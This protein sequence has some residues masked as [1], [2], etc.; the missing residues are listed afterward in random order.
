MNKLRLG[1]AILTFVLI[2][3]GCNKNKEV[4][5]ND[6]GIDI[7]FRRLQDSI[8][9]YSKIKNSTV[10]QISVESDDAVQS[11]G[12]RSY[13]YTI[14]NTGDTAWSGVLRF[15]LQINGKNPRFFL[16]GFIYG[17][18][19]AEVPIH[20]KNRKQWPR[21]RSG[22]TQ[23]PYS[24]YFFVRSDRLA[25]PVSMVYIN[26]RVYGISASP[27]RIY[28]NDTVK[29]WQPKRKGDF[30]GFNG[31]GC[32]LDTA[33]AT[34]SYTLGYE[35]APWLYVAGDITKEQPF[36]DSNCFTI[37]PEE[38]RS[39]VLY[40]YDFESEDERGIN[41]V[42]RHQN[43][44]FHEPPTFKVS[45]QTALKDLATAVY[46]D[47]YSDEIKLYVTSLRLINDTV[48]KD[49]SASIAW[50]GGLQVATPLLMA[51]VRLKNNDMRNQAVE[52]VQNVVDNS[53]NPKSGL[54]F[55]AYRNG[56][57]TTEGWWEY[58]L[59]KPLEGIAAHSSYLCGQALYYILKA[60]EYEKEYYNN[61]HKDWL[62]FVKQVSNRVE[63]TKNNDG[64]YP[65]RWS[66]ETGE[67]ID[68]DAMGG[69]WCLATRAYLAKILNDANMI[70]E[71]EKSIDHYWKKFVKKMECYGT[72]HDTWRATEE[73]GILAFVKAAGILHRLTENDKYLTYLKDGIDYEFTWKYCYNTPVQ[74]PP[75]SKLNWSSSGASGT[76]I[77][78]PHVHPMGCSISDDILYLAEKTGDDYYQ[79][80]AMDV[81]YWPVQAYNS[82]HE[83]FDHGKKGWMSERF[84]PHEG[85]VIEK[86]P[87][88]S[89]ASTWFI[90]HPWASG[91]AIEALAGN[92]WNIITAEK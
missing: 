74:I 43:A 47:A 10:L 79:Q 60:Y 61:E 6:V 76:S 31:F 54:P 82:Y 13:Q 81:V 90:Y 27:Y 12:I 56:E 33:S 83:K 2:F 22:D 40:L 50:T 63:T 52:C 57:W 62:Q 26:G 78:N 36:S 73:E 87:D 8:K 19:R 17:T 23:M 34:I 4:D 24:D 9:A 91:S 3:S 59:W 58:Y 39:F 55:D 53:L 30:S 89:P 28:A 69:V 32:K 29:Q 21:L 25:Y 1:T 66:R 48:K 37:S 44:M 38:S 80:R 77:A 92:A 42:I 20:P 88:G 15:N 35:N 68:Y 41:K 85:L 84:C 18:N 65:Y 49:N 14:T 51:S 86:Y 7:T 67:A 75:L 64:E 72:P 70:K 71:C 45:I 11:D 5:C 16:P 46:D